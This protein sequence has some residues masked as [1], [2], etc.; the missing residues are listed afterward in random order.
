M[1]SFF[2]AL[3]TFAIVIA[4][5]I[6]FMKWNSIMAWWNKPKGIDNGA[7]SLSCQAEYDAAKALV[8]KSGQSCVQ[9]VADLVCPSDS[10]FVV[11]VN[12]CVEQLLKDKG[13]KSPDQNGSN[14]SSGNNNTSVQY[15]LEVSNPNG[16]FMYYQQ[17]LASGGKIYSASNLLIPYGT[18]LKLV[19]IWQTNLSTQPFS[20]YYETEYKDYGAH[21][22]F[23]ATQDVK[24]I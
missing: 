17:D 2:Y 12:P 23:F 15:D 21:S 20:G 6:I 3:L 11:S 8:S 14:N 13:W 10:T 5:L 16:A 9:T 7:A 18:K 19:K 4:A 1:R 22:G 24:K